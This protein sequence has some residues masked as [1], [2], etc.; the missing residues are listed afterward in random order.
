VIP[1]KKDIEAMSYFRHIDST[2]ETECENGINSKNMNNKIYRAQLY[3][4]V[5]KW[6]N[7]NKHEYKFGHRIGNVI[8]IINKDS[9]EIY[10]KYSLMSKKER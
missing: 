9:D 7:C 4:F 8:D 6:I 3:Q 5:D 10:I 1:K 2:N